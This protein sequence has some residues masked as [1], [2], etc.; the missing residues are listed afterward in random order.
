MNIIKCFVLSIFLSLFFSKAESQDWATIG[1]RWTYTIGGC[2]LNQDESCRAIYGVTAVQDTMTKGKDAHRLEY[3]IERNSGS[4][5]KFNMDIVVASENNK[6]Y[7]FF[8]DEWHM[9]Y[10]FDAEVGDTIEVI[11]NPQMPC[12]QIGRF[13]CFE[14]DLLE[15]SFGYIV[16][17][18]SDTIISGQSLRK[19]NIKPLDAVFGFGSDYILERIGV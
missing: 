14:S 4:Q 11:I 13:D 1:A 19:Q 2:N 15:D 10:D 18:Y 12:Y 6:F 17:G 7:H 9:I 3:T 8:E 5:R 16:T